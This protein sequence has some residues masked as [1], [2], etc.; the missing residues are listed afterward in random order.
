MPNLTFYDP[1]FTGQPNV[2]KIER[3]HV[4]SISF[5]SINM[6]PA[7]NDTNGFNRCSG[8]GNTWNSVYSWR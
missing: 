4:I 6:E 1:N 7:N 8:F 2:P 5:T 3:Y